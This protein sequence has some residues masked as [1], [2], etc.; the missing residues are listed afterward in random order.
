VITVRPLVER[1]DI[2]RAYRAVFAEA[3]RGVPGW[4]DPPLAL[5]LARLDARHEP[6]WREAD[7]ILL[8][9][10]R[11]GRAVGR[12]L[13]FVPPG[14]ARAAAGERTGRFAFFDAVDEAAVAD[15]LFDEAL[16]WLHDRGCSA[17]EG[18]LGFSM[19]DEVGLLVEGFD[20]PPAF[21]MPFNPP[22]ADRHL[23][24]LGFERVRAFH[25]V[26]WELDRGVPLRADRKDLGA[27]AGLLLRPFSLARREA[28][29]VALLEVY[30][31]AFASSWGFEPLS[32][33]A[34][35]ILVDQLVAFGDP[36]LVRI[37]EQEG[38][39]VGFALVVPDPCAHLHATRGLPDW[40]R[41]AWLALAARLRRIRHAR[42]IT[43]AVRPRHQGQ[44]IAH[45][46]V[47]DVA[48]TG[49]RLGYRAAEL[50][51]V[52]AANDAMNGILAGLSLP[53]TKRYA[54]YRRDLP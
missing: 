39:P 37:A 7:R 49:I 42:F 28:D 16:R 10:E 50:S 2:A 46:L 19:H 51:Y 53:R 15:A 9:A 11:G 27:S 38:G 32:A 23:R 30:N 36:R 29:T 5:H 35:R 25:S 24:R 54:L 34:A 22:H 14:A 52:D 17:V 47:R 43:L 21:L 48:E 45:A 20:R 8:V 3:F 44:G 18:P 31:D 33:P 40:L 4:H 1:R 41:L 13:A 6:I 26:A 12:L